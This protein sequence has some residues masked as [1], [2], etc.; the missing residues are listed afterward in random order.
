MVESYYLCPVVH[1]PWTTGFPF[2]QKSWLSQ[3]RWYQKYRSHSYGKGKKDL[4]EHVAP[5]FVC[6]APY[7]AR[8]ATTKGSRAE[9][10]SSR[11]EDSREDTYAENSRPH[12]INMLRLLVLI[13]VPKDLADWTCQAENEAVFVAA[14]TGTLQ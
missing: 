5:P 3:L 4:H 8:I 14:G 12:E 1:R 9:R 10:R 6:I 13:C 11:K 2:T 7:R